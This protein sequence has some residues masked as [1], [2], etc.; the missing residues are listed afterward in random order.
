MTIENMNDG[1]GKKI[2]EALRMQTEDATDENMITEEEQEIEE[3]EETEITED[4]DDFDD[5]EILYADSFAESIKANEEAKSYE[6]LQ[7]SISRTLKPQSAI[8]TAFNNSLAQNIGSNIG[9]TS[10]SVPEDIE[11]P[12]NVVILRQLIA[13]LPTGVSKQTG[14]LIIKQTMEALGISM[15]S[16]LQEAKQVQEMLSSSSKECQHNI[17][18]YR[19]QIGLLEAKTQQYQRQNAVMSEIINLFIHTGR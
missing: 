6:H 8:D 13:K 16:V 11:Y 4:D 17:I 18:E 19:R 7:Q 2:V 9:N 15:N 3:E 14:A 10:Y 5:D 12:A 1:V